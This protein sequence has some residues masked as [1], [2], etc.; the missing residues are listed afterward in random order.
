MLAIIITVNN[1]VSKIIAAKL[2]IKINIFFQIK[3]AEVKSAD[4]GSIL[5]ENTRS[6]QVGWVGDN[7]VNGE[8]DALNSRVES[9][10]EFSIKTAEKY[11]VVNYGLGGHYVCH[12]DPFSK[13]LVRIKKIQFFFNLF[14]SFNM[15]LSSTI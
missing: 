15:L 8:L 5:T 4:G 1:I 3:D 14:K 12:F 2:R 9:M 7:D 11:Q 13:K 10:T 6:G